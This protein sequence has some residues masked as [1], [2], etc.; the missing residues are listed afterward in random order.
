M[1][2]RQDIA[3]YI[4][5][6]V[7][8]AGVVRSGKMFG[9]YALYC[10]DK[11]VALICDNQLF[12]KPTAAGRTYLGEVEEGQPYPG[13][14]PWFLIAEDYWDDS[15][16]LTGLISVTTPEVPLPK[17]RKKKTPKS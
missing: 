1:A 17:P 12:V 7:S 11:V 15:D 5:S 10:E 2:T 3:D 6:Q 13:A 8:G 14:K 16:W 4:V 9:E